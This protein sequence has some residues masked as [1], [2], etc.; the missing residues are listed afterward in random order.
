MSRLHAKGALDPRRDP[1]CMLSTPCLIF[2]HDQ[3]REQHS[4]SPPLQTAPRNHQLSP[5]NLT[6]FA[7]NTLPYSALRTH[8]DIWALFKLLDLASP[9]ERDVKPLYHGRKSPIPDGWGANVFSQEESSHGMHHMST[10][11]GVSLTKS[12]RRSYW[13]Q[14][15]WCV[16]C[17]V[18]PR[19]SFP[20]L[21]QDARSTG[22]PACLMRALNGVQPEGK[23]V[24]VNILIICNF[25]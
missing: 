4:S 6:L 10:G 17:D 15:T 23:R 1:W 8:L 9:N 11:Q 20:V 3:A 18:T 14:L 2:C 5:T 13:L 16:S 19:N 7:R 22:R 21:A 24:H 25:S 12:E